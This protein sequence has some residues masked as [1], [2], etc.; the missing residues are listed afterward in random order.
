MDNEQVAAVEVETEKAQEPVQAQEQVTENTEAA[1]AEAQSATVE[2][3]SSEKKERTVEAVKAENKKL[4]AESTRRR[5]K[6]KQSQETIKSL[7]AELDEIKSK[8]VEQTES[9]D[10]EAYQDRLNDQRLDVKVRERE[11]AREEMRADEQ[12]DPHTQEMRQVTDSYNESK[13]AFLETSGVNPEV[14]NQHESN[15]NNALGGR[16]QHER[17]LLIKEFSKLG[18]DVVIE[19][20]TDPELLNTILCGDIITAV[21]DLRS[22]KSRLNQKKVVSDAPEPVPSL[23]SGSGARPAGSIES[24]QTLKEYR[25]HPDYKG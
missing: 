2:T 22:A 14:Y 3:P 6:E 5:N 18:Q 4:I 20:A 25:A 12:V 23:D 10:F 21:T 19:A 24:C 15:V 9:E 11:I 8:P 1:V 17:D 16:P 7:K 13:A